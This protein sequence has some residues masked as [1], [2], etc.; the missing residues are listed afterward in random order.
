MFDIFAANNKLL[1]QLQ[2]EITSEHF[3]VLLSLRETNDGMTK[4]FN[5][6]LHKPK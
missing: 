5:F 4:D 6:F 3:N 1:Q 2:F